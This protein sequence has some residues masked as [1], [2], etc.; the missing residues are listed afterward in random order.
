MAWEVDLGGPRPIACHEVV[1]GSFT[2]TVVD[3]VRGRD[4]IRVECTSM[5]RKATLHEMLGACIPK[6]SLESGPRPEGKRAAKCV[7]ASRVSG[8][9]L[10]AK[11][12]K[13]ELGKVCGWLD[14]YLVPHCTTISQL[15]PSRVRQSSKLCFLRG[16]FTFPYRSGCFRHFPEG[17]RNERPADEVEIDIGGGISPT[18]HSVKAAVVSRSTSGI[19]KRTKYITAVYAWWWRPTSTKVLEFPTPANAAPSRNRRSNIEAAV[20]LSVLRYSQCWFV[21]FSSWTQ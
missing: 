5:Q 16:I 6:K 17:Y 12:E 15:S 9:M 18:L 1:I 4:Y 8:V 19:L 10:D 13:F 2:R 14:W 3:K 21:T 7:A 11:M 20:S